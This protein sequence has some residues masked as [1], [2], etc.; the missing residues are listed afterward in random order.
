M[1]FKGRNLKPMQ[2]DHIAIGDIVCINGI[3]GFFDGLTSEAI[4][5]IDENDHDRPIKLTEIVSVVRLTIFTED[6]LSSIS[7]NELKAA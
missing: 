6:N 1:I 5:L 3:I 7:I 4:W 2:S